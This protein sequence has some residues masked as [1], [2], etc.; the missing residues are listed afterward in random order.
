MDQHP[1]DAPLEALSAELGSIYLDYSRDDSVDTLDLQKNQVPATRRLIPLNALQL[2]PTHILLRLLLLE[3]ELAV[4]SVP[5][6]PNLGLLFNFNPDQPHGAL[7]SSSLNVL[8]DTPTD[9]ADFRQLVDTPPYLDVHD[10]LGEDWDEKGAAVRAVG[11]GNSFSVVKRTVKDFQF[12]RTLGEGS[13]LT[14]VLATDRHTSAQYAVKILDKRHIIKEKKVKYVNIEKHALNRLSGTRGIISLYFTFQDKALLYFV[15]DYAAHGELLSLIKKYGTLNEECTRHFGAQILDALRYMHEN[16]VIHRD[17]KPENILLDRQMRVQIADF[18]TARMLEK[19][20]NQPEEYPV[21]V[22]AKSFVGTAEYVS[23]E[24]LESKY[25]GK[26]G[27]V[28]AFGCIVYQMIAGKPPFKATNDY[29][30]FQKITKLQYAFSAGFPTIIR[31]LIKQILVLQPS[32]RAT[33]PQIQ[34]H[35]FFQGID[36]SVP[37]KV[38]D[39]EVPELG[40]YKMTAKSMLKVPALGKSPSQSHIVTHKKAKK[41]NGDSKRAVSEG[42]HS[43]TVN[44]A[45]VAAFVLHKNDQEPENP[46]EDS[47]SESKPASRSSTALRQPRE[48]DYIPGTNIL[49][50][51]VNMRPSMTHVNPR[52]QSKRQI[53]RPKAKLLEITPLSNVEIAWQAYL[54]HL[55][56]RVLRIGPVIAS[57][58]ATEVFERKNKG[59]LHDAPLGATSKL[60]A[61]NASIKGGTSLLS[62]VVKG[63]KVGLRSNGPSETLPVEVEDESTAIIDYFE[64]EDIPPSSPTSSQAEEA[65]DSGFGASAK[66]G[67]AI[68]K[69]FLSHSDRNG[70]ENSSNGNAPTRQ[71]L[72]EKPRTCTVLVT[73]HG[74]VLIFFKSPSST[75]YKLV[76]EIR[77]NHSFIRFKEVVSTLT[78]NKYLKMVS[79]TGIFAI[80]S[81]ATTF[82]FEVEKLD[83]NQWTEALANA[84]LNQFERLKQNEEKTSRESS[85]GRSATPSPKLAAS[86]SFSSVKAEP[87]SERPPS[88][89]QRLSYSGDQRGGFLTSKL[90]TKSVKRKPPPPIPSLNGSLNMSTGLGPSLSEK[91]GSA[92][93]HAAQL[94]V[95]NNAHTPPTNNRRS[96]FGRDDDGLHRKVASPTS[97][98]SSG[99]RPKV[100]SLNSKFLARS[101]R[102]K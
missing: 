60:Q 18:G 83:I 22:R 13:Y 27:D 24:L 32:R 3:D 95:S 34:T 35:F 8:L 30:T 97:S 82:A 54:H 68:F 26:P 39:V 59:L 43:N 56:E 49:R 38:W 63:S 67:K 57:R 70:S 62:Q 11:S 72:L 48:A 33:I 98:A 93:L 29:L 20:A 21:D 88:I 23:P 28:W 96:S 55:D 92:M 51:T 71:H 41:P 5:Q 40:P 46:P 2:P 99:T 87:T 100:T 10:G 61:A 81:S 69:K 90:R 73:S 1:H 9:E 80:E 79:T 101:H 75:D 19:K 74:R 45:L 44:P 16:G 91:T 77:L 50:P 102:S 37:E 14:V 58:L 94:A 4:R 12:G 31:D 84:K 42:Q 78:S 64:I 66:L 53:A 65:P 76:T 85:R 47:D 25:C 15:L 52:L 7:T 89:Q 6:T 36:F 17:I 86:P